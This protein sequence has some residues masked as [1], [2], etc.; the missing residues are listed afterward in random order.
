MPKRAV[1]HAASTGTAA[2]TVQLVSGEIINFKHGFLHVIDLKMLTQFHSQRT[3]ILY[4]AY[5]TIVYK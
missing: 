2:V 5:Q 4:L 1:S 3:L